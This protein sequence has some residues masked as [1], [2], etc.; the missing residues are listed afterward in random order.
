MF[1]ISYICVDIYIHI[2]K[3]KQYN[4]HIYIMYSIVI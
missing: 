3:I 1:E 4:I 2:Q